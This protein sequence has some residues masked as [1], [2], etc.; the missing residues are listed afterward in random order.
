MKTS[1]NDH[2]ASP[3]TCLLAAIA[4]AL[5]MVG[6]AEGQ[7]FIGL[8]QVPSG[9][10]SF[11][12]AVDG[13]GDVVVGYASIGTGD[14]ESQA[15]LWTREGNGGTLRDLGSLP[16]PNW[17][18]CA[19]VS[20]DGL[21][22][23]GYQRT[24]SNDQQATRWHVSGNGNVAI[25][26]LAGLDGEGGAYALDVSGDGRVM[27]G[28]S[29]S[30]EGFRAVRWTEHGVENLGVME[31]GNDSQAYATNVD[32]SI[33]VGFGTSAEE[34]Y[35][36]FRWTSGGG[37][38]SLG[39]LNTGGTS[40][41]FANGVSDSGAV[42][43]GES[44]TAQGSRAFRWTERTGMVALPIPAGMLFSGAYGVSADG[45][46]IVGIAG[47]STDRRVLVWS[48]TLQWID[49]EAYLSGRGVDLS[50]WDLQGASAVSADGGSI[51]GYGTHNGAHEAWIASLPP[52][53]APDFDGS[54]HLDVQDIIAFLNAW[55]ALDPSADFNGL[56]GITVQDIF[57]FLSAWFSGR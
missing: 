57:D 10:A 55:F 37:M 15:F 56:G 49:L 47:N 7:T 42:V 50:G 21:V 32:G 23:A 14:G 36:A 13:H 34:G 48:R 6:R 26:M 19:A 9:A 45:S 38:R 41:A 12:T 17:A 39:A 3:R 52:R 46:V 16:A 35:S 24:I 54:N 43:I 4:L 18:L 22:L 1:R 20:R 28:T 53:C 8:G 5:A 27:V 30:P 31:G 51:V 40:F 44:S 25:D 11:A 2:G 29:R 33:V